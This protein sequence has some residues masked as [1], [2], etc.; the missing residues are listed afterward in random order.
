MRPW[1]RREPTNDTA[2][3][4]ASEAREAEDTTAALKPNE[5]G[6]ALPKLIRASSLRNSGHTRRLRSSRG[7][8]LQCSCI[9]GYALV[10]SY[11]HINTTIRPSPLVERKDG[12]AMGL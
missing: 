1:K 4:Y 5:R 9:A 7:S 10:V 2:D 3:V 12:A 6:K 8:H 11:G